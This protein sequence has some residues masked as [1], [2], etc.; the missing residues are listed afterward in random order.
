MAILMA[1]I[2]TIIMT[3]AS[4]EAPEKRAIIKDIQTSQKLDTTIK[5]RRFVTNSSYLKCSFIARYLSTEIAVMTRKDTPAQIHDSEPVVK[6][7]A[8]QNARLFR[9]IS[10]KISRAFV[11]CTTRPTKKS[12]N[13]RQ[14][15]SVF[16]GVRSA[17]VFH[18]AS[19]INELPAVADRAVRELITIKTT[20]VTYVDV[21]SYHSSSRWKGQCISVA[22]GSSDEVTAK[23]G[24]SMLRG[25]LLCVLRVSLAS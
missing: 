23:V 9:W 12:E 18:T 2:T 22:C 20:L 24:F 19:R 6:I 25:S 11:G 13:A 1:S 14:Q 7:S 16:E 4:Y 8:T 5:M 21:K 10:K 15:S 3:R 17:G